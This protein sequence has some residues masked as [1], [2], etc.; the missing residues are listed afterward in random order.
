MNT[1]DDI[2]NL[3]VS[4]Q[5]NTWSGISIEPTIGIV[6]EEIKSDKYETQINALRTKLKSGDKEYYDSHKR[7]LPAVTFSA[8]FDLKRVSDK[9]KKYNSLIVIDI[10]KL[11]SEQLVENYNHLLNDE[12]VFSFWRSPSNN[13]FKGLVAIDY[14]IENKEVDLN[15][16]H[17]SAFKKLS[18]YFIDK[19]NMELDKSGSDITRLCFLS[20]D[21]QLILKSTFK[22]FVIKDE[23]IVLQTKKGGNKTTEF[24]FASSKDALNNPLGKNSQTDRK[25]MT[26]IIRYLTNKKLTITCTYGEWCKVAMAIANTFTYDIGIKY[27]LKLSVLDL[28]KYNEISCVNFLNNCYEARKGKVNFKSIIYLANQKGYKTKDQKKG[29]PKAED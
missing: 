13:G 27:F 16:L 15:K 19:Y 24:K 9:L 29:V 1:I 7:Q 3:K 23:D 8:S 10:D 17:K 2:L 11:E 4:Y 6:L 21:K 14:I 25:I 12:C 22:A 26:D 18:D 28:D 5:A 20:F